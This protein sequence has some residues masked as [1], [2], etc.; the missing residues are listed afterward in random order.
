[1]KKFILFMLSLLLFR[2]A[3]AED[4]NLI[5]DINLQDD[6]SGRV[7]SQKIRTRVEVSVYQNNNIYILPDSDLLGS[8]STA[9]TP[10]SININN[11][12]TPTKWHIQKTNRNS[13]T[14]AISDTTIIIDRNAGT[15]SYNHLF[16]LKNN[17]IQTTGFGNCERINPNVKKF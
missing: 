17:S 12:S 7:V 11:Y 4:I 9:K 15:I 6:S 10:S 3:F 5:C 16:T 13:S 1:M 2:S 8:V 14:G